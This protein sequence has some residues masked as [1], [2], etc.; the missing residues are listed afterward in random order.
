MNQRRIYA[1]L[2]GSLLLAGP[3]VAQN[4]VVIDKVTSREASAK[5][6]VTVSGVEVVNTNLS[7]DEVTKLLSADTPN[8]QL[9]A[10][11]LKM[12][13]DSLKIGG[14][15]VQGEMSKVLVGPFEASSVDK[16]RFARAMLSDFSVNYTEKGQPTGGVL[17]GRKLDMKRGN[18]G[19]FLA[20]L[21]SGKFE[22]A[23]FQVGDVAWDGFDGSFTDSQT[24]ADAPGGN[25]VKV[26]LRGLTAST[27]YAGDTPVSSKGEASGFTFAPAPASEL[28]KGLRS[29]GYERL[30]L[31][32]SGA[33]RYEP[34]SQRLVL[35]DYTITS[36]SAGRL[37]LS[38]EVSGVDPAA[39]AS[40]D[41]TRRGMAL[42]GAS[43]EGLKLNFV[44]EGLVE[45]SFTFAADKQ[46]KT[47]AAL[48]SEVSAMAGQLL[49]LFLAGDPQ[50]LPLAQSVQ[51]FLTTPK[52]FTLTL[53]ARGAPVPLARLG[54][55]RDPMTFLALVNVTLVANQ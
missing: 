13:A 45:K 42:L 24:P 10:L 38:G 48:R 1:A 16:G 50:S 46:G 6:D 29:F 40:G 41:A 52:N 35:Q 43:V 33:G 7:S 34:A 27:E 21:Q 36:P 37:S 9:L 49:P 2:V 14:V 51:T 47:P 44:N 25:Q 31:G 17:T 30:E 22:S 15:T 4:R 53:K 39:L 3:A 20:A 19:P 12:T 5:N 32:V 55:I 23:S 28:G 11:A 26:S 54:T 18:L 8:D